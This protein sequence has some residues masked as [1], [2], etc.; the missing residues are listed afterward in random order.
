MSLTMR[1]IFT[2]VLLGYF[3]SWVLYLFNFES[4]KEHY[5][6]AAKKIL[7]F[8]LFI[9]LGILICTG[10]R[11]AW[12]P[13]YY[14]EAALPFAMLL[15]SF[16]ME[17]RYKARYIMLFSLPIALLISALTL[18]H[19]RVG[20]SEPEIVRNAWFWAHVSFIFAG[21]SGFVAAVSSAIMYLWQ[22]AQLKSK[23]PGQAF[24]KLP[25]LDV[26]DKIH[27]RSLVGGVVLFSLGILAG[28]FWASDLRE[29]GRVLMDTK[30]ILSFVTCFSYWIIVALRLSRLRRGQKIALS[31]LIV[32]VLL[33]IT[34][35]SS[36]ISPSSFH[37]GI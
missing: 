34:F 7:S 21:L 3:V 22:S 24:L 16:I 17:I 33:F 5:F 9:H 14:V 37:Q 25:P 18:W 36:Y 8:C 10:I 13:A 20:G 6:G 23:H 26:L 30:V 35:M 29:L 2:S 27:F 19:T 1:I 11:E 15:L 4:P 32:F 28:L 12:P 31:T